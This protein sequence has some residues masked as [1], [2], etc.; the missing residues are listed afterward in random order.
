MDLRDGDV[1]LGGIAPTTSAPSRAIG[2]TEA[3]RRSRYRGCAARE[4]RIG[5]VAVELRGDLRGDVIQP[6]GVEHVQRLELAVRVPPFGGHRLELGDLGGV[7]RWP[8]SRVLAFFPA[9][10]VG[11]AVCRVYIGWSWTK[12]SGQK[13]AARSIST[14]R[15]TRSISGCWMWATATDLCGAM[16]QSRRRAGCGAAWRPRRRLQPGDA[17]LFRPRGLPHHPVRS[18]RLRPVAAPCQRRGNTTWHLVADIERSANAG[19]RRAGSSSA[20][21][22]ARRWRWSM[23]RPIPTGAPTWCCAASS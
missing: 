21:A 19:H 6:A 1:A 14:R 16:R 12:F 10:C 5:K 8:L 18:A 17:A 3:R 15:S 11:S 23:R 2:S 22:G 9:S 13:R 20:A 7:D 4:G